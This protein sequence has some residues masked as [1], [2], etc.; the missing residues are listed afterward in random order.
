MST[1]ESCPLCGRTKGMNHKKL[2]Y[3]YKVCKKCRNGFANRRQFAFFIDSFLIQI[4]Q[5]ACVA[6][7]AAKLRSR[8]DFDVV[9]ILY[10]VAAG[11]RL[12]RGL[13]ARQGHDGSASRQSRNVPADRPG[14][15]GGQEPAGA[16]SIHAAH[17]WL[18]IAQR[19]SHRR[20][21]GE[22]KGDLA[23]VCR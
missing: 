18:W 23:Q 15:R 4:A 22:V 13:L 7:V 8:T 21:L 9:W 3:G 5:I 2:L 1:G 16:N 14:K 10:F 11:Q 17:R 20:R 12:V 6:A 19:V